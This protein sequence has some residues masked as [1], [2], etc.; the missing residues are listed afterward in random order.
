MVRGVM[1]W[2]LRDEDVEW[3]IVTEYGE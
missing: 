1:E 3:Y 2:L